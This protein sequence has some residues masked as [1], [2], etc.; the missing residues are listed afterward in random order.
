MTSVKEFISKLEYYCSYQERCHQEVTQKLYDLGCPV[1]DHAQI[2]VHLIQ[3]GFLN[4]E[5]FALHFAQSKNRQKKWGKQK[6]KNALKLKGITPN[7]IQQS[8]QSIDQDEYL[9][10]FSTTAEKTWSETLEKNFWKKQQK[11]ISK[12]LQKGF[13]RELIFEFL[14]AKKED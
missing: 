9:Q 3:Y 13:E 5:R 10:T 11:V 14:E 1:S 2:V 6:I 4:E 7:L 12:L 8:L